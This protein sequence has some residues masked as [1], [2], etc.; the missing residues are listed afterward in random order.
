MFTLKEYRI[1]EKLAQ[2]FSQIVAQARNT[3]SGYLGSPRPE[4]RSE[5][6]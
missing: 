4:R 6:S 5:R 3:P 1:A 2:N